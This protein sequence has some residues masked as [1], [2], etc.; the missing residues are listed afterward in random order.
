M[1][2]TT[3]IKTNELFQFLL[4]HS[5]A[6]ISGKV[7]FVISLAAAVMFLRG[8]PDFAGNETKMIVLGFLAL[9]F[10]V[11]NP[12]MLYTRAK[13]QKLMNPAYKNAMEYELDEEGIKLYAGGQEGGIPWNRIIKIKESGSLYMLYT[14]RINAFLWPKK[15]MGAREKEIMD[16]VL[17]HID[18]KEV[19]LPKRMRG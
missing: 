14:T 8:I 11:V 12:V 19:Q 13:K 5:Y 18:S 17:E 7:G 4:R 15:D 10:T 6:G 9:L 1:K 3:N 2:F 16:Y